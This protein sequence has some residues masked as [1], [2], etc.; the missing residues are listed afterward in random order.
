MILLVIKLIGQK[1]DILL[2]FVNVYVVY[3][4]SLIQHMFYL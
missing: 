1:Y 3:T 4:F 2:V